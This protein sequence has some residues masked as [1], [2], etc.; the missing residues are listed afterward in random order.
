MPLRSLMRVAKGDLAPLVRSSLHYLQASGV[1]STTQLGY[2][3]GADRALAMSM[4]A[5]EHGIVVR[6]I[7]AVEPAS[8]EPRSL[9][10]LA[11][12]FQS[13]GPRFR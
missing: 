8:L 9:Y 12:D 7:V 6:Q 1:T 11:R 4:A 13:C 2:S 5:P 3:F 10:R